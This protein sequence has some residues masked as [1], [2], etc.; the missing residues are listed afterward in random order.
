MTRH[1]EETLAFAKEHCTHHVEIGAYDNDVCQLLIGKCCTVDVPE[2]GIMSLKVENGIE[3]KFYTVAEAICA[4]EAIED[5][6]QEAISIAH[7]SAMAKVERD[8]LASQI[9]TISAGVI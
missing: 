4:A 5:G 6:I 8:N 9:T 3:L 2:I 1:A 7:V